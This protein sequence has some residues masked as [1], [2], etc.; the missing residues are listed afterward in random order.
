IV[1]VTGMALAVKRDRQ[2]QHMP[3]ETGRLRQSQLHLQPRKLDLL[4]PGE[5]A[6]KHRRQCKADQ[7]WRQ[8]ALIAGDQHRI[9]ERLG[10][11]RYRKPRSDQQQADQD[12]VEEAVSRSFGAGKKAVAESRRLSAFGEIWT[13]LKG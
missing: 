13:G 11:G 2:P 7:Q 10:E 4:E 6:A 3:E 1:D 9:D 8:P 5:D 12:D